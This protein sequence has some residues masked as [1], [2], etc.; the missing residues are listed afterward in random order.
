MIGT[1]GIPDEMTPDELAREQEQADRDRAWQLHDARAKQLL[2]DVGMGG[3]RRRK[4]A[5]EQCRKTWPKLSDDDVAATVDRAIQLADELIARQAEA[6]A[7]KDPLRMN[8]F[9]RNSERRPTH[10]TQ[11]TGER[12]HGAPLEDATKTMTTTTKAAMT[13]EEATEL[14][15]TRLREDRA[16]SCGAVHREAQAQGYTATY[17]AFYAGPWKKAKAQLAP[18]ATTEETPPSAAPSEGTAD[19]ER[20]PASE[21]PAGA[22]QT[23]KVSSTSENG[24]LV[25]D[26]AAGSGTFL[27]LALSAQPHDGGTRITVTV[28]ADGDAGSAIYNLTRRLRGAAAA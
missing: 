23:P 11:Q 27:I 4:G 21:P 10:E 3:I 19:P 28:D 5:M 13:N 14:A 6:K 7:N 15:L 16:A 26:P 9:S 24:R 2:G 17:Q 22:A 8:A 18:P 12:L 1:D 25:L 20:T